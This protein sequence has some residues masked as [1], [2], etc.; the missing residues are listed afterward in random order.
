MQWG[1]YAGIL[2]AGLLLYYFPNDSNSTPPTFC[3]AG[4][5][6]Q[7]LPLIHRRP[8]MTIATFNAE[9]L[10]DGI[11]DFIPIGR[12]RG[13]SKLAVDVVHAVFELQK[14]TLER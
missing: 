4:V 6:H 14:I 1:P 11:K 2:F 8:T 10:F 3:P 12:H 13:I 5:G 9:W 7:A